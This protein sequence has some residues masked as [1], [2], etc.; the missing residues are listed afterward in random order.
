MEC[1]PS[2]TPLKSWELW[3]ELLE[4]QF[5]QLNS[6]KQGEVKCAARRR[7]DQFKLTPQVLNKS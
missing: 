7:W 5:L 1:V 3:E 4:P 2:V 6:P